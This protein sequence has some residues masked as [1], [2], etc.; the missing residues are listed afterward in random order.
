MRNNKKRN[1]SK[2]LRLRTR[3]D[4]LAD[5]LKRTGLILQGTITARTIEDRDNNYKI[6]GPYYQWTRKIRAKTVTVNL[7]HSQAKAYQTAIDNNKKLEKIIKEM[8]TLSL[9]ICEANTRGVKKRK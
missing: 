6:Y 1:N 8:R 9:K 7:T 3:Y 2:L 4:A 5:E